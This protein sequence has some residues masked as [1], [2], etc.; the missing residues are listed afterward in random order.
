MN[1]LHMK[2]HSL[3]EAAMY[4]NIVCIYQTYNKYSKKVDLRQPIS[5]I[6][7]DPSC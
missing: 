7:S 4:R 5:L 3:F 1:R 2:L 6:V